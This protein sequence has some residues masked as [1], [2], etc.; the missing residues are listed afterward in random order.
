M[1]QCQASS[2]TV[3]MARDSTV[4]KVTMRDSLYWLRSIAAGTGIGA[5]IGF[6]GAALGKLFGFL[7]N[8][9][10]PLGFYGVFGAVFGAFTGGLLQP[11]FAGAKYPCG[12]K[13]GRSYRVSQSFRS[14]RTEFQEGE[15]VVFKRERRCWLPLEYG[16]REHDIYEFVEQCSNTFKIISSEDYPRPS[17]WVKCFEEMGE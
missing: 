5:V 2:I 6:A 17:L 1:I 10:L 11:Y 8:D 15:V 13:K 9:W 14:G 7:T 12:L 16:E 3:I 4:T